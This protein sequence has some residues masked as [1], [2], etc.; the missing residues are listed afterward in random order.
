MA[1][2]LIERLQ[3]A[4]EW[5]PD[6]E[7]R[8][9]FREAAAALAQRD[10]IPRSEDARRLD[11]LERNAGVYVWRGTEREYLTNARGLRE[12]ID[13]AEAYEETHHTEKHTAQP[14]ENACDLKTREL[15]D[16]ELM[17]ILNEHAPSQGEPF[18]WIPFARDVIRAT[19][20]IARWLP[21]NE[22]L[23]KQIEN[24]PDDDPS[25]GDFECTR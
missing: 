21:S 5:P 13:A 15:T 8:S 7:S 17:A 10:G 16:D 4:A 6:E 1:N 24:D 18:E 14:T 23:R 2:T 25:A 22:T 9:L 11:W 3:Y 19:T 20:G 12:S